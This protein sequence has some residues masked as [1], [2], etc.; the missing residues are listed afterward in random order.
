MNFIVTHKDKQARVHNKFRFLDSPKGWLMGDIL[1]IFPIFLSI[2]LLVWL[3]QVTSQNESPSLLNSVDSYEE[4]LEIGIWKMT[5]T[6]FQ[7][8]SNLFSI[9]LL[10]RGRLIHTSHP[11]KY[12]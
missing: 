12:E 5:L 3:K 1:D 11:Q 8:V 7:F 2:F 9:F 4:D 10:G 6:L